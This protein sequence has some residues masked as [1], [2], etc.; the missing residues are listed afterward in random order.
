MKL[1]EL[2]IKH[3]P[4]DKIHPDAKFFAQDTCFGEKVLF[5]YL[6]VPKIRHVGKGGYWVGEAASGAKVHLPEAAEDGRDTV[7][8]R[9][10]L[11]YLW[12]L[13]REQLEYLWSLQGQGYTLV[14]DGSNPFQNPT[15]DL[16]DVIPSNFGPGKILHPRNV[17]WV[18]VIAYRLVKN[19]SRS[20]VKYHELDHADTIVATVIEANLKGR[21]ANGVTDVTS[22]PRLEG[23]QAC[24]SLDGRISANGD[25][26]VIIT[27]KMWDDYVSRKIRVGDKV[28]T[29]SGAIV[30]VLHIGEEKAFVRHMGGEELALS[31]NRIT[32]VSE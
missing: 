5:Q 26:L 28:K 9:E 30:T 29:P 15:D 10:Q 2:I 17:L 24:F 3:V 14:F 8:T 20:R 11:E 7:V 25:N 21:L 31:L 6:I 23:E 27:R 12:S 16:V 4:R 1:I 22:F 19:E 32:R 13:T 18:N